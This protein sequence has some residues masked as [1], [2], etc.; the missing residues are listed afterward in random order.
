MFY[1]LILSSIFLFYVGYFIGL[2]QGLNQEKN[3]NV[4]SV[5]ENDEKFVNNK[6][7]IHEENNKISKITS[8]IGIDFGSTSSGYSIIFDPY[9]D[10]KSIDI[11]E[12]I[13]S[14]I[15]IHKTSQDGLF[16][17]IKNINLINF[18]LWIIYWRGCF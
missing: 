2:N 5:D 16:I 14:Q 3:R 18:I 17:I 7:I 4:K 8:I 9:Y 15:I 12:I 1:L 11:N 10:S 13:S 6:K